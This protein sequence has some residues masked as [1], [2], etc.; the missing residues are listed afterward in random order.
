MGQFNLTSKIAKYVLFQRTQYIRGANNRLLLALNR[1]TNLPVFNLAVQLEGVLRRDTISQLYYEEIEQEYKGIAPFLS[2]QC[3]SWLDI[4]CGIGGID[5]FLW[6]HF[7]QDENSSNRPEIYLLDRSQTEQKVWYGFKNSSA[8][9]NSFEA[10]KSFL[11]DNGIDADRINTR[12]A[13]DDNKIEIEQELDLVISLI[14]WGF[15]YSVETYLDRV[16]QLLKPGGRLIIDVRKQTGGFDEI[17]KLF[18]STEIILD[19]SKYER[20]LAIK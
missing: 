14:S 18:S 5:Y 4:G 9:Y 16:H 3:E 13:T 20:I 10:T 1:R 12:N 17:N 11:V 15:H 8:F 6:R 19:T 7:T 2:D